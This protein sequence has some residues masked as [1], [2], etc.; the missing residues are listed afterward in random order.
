MTHRNTGLRPRRPAN[1][2]LSLVAPRGAFHQAPAITASGRSTGSGPWLEATRTHGS[3]TPEATLSAR[4]L[5]HNRP[6]SPPDQRGPA[7]GRT[8]PSAFEDL[9]DDVHGSRRGGVEARR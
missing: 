6:M 5:R 3:E 4:D 7:T 1:D 8:E 2:E 9:T